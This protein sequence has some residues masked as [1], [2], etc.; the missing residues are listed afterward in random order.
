MMNKL[1]KGV[2][3]AVVALLVVLGCTTSF[4]G[5]VGGPTGPAIGTDEVDLPAEATQSF[6]TAFQ[7]DPVPED[8][9]GPK[10]VVA[11][12]I[13]QDGLTD[14]VSAW[15]QNQP[16]QLHLQR[17]TSAGVISF[18]TVS[19][20]GTTPIAVVAGLEVGQI[21]DDGW[22]DVVVLSKATAFLGLCPTNP[23][24]TISRL[25]GEII[26]LFSP[27][28]AAAV[29]DGDAWTEMMLV[30]PFVA[31]RWIHN[32]YPGIEIVDYNESKTKPEW[33]GFTSLVV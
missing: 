5:T 15:N 30:N 21:N 17:R 11:A 2:G 3:C 16:V 23:P 19:L 33:S 6:F 25:E 1:L 13:D 8:T 12:D 10:F 7:V 28:S 18:R 27:G 20:G 31:D 4:T 22:L 14:L 26:V 29:P 32:Q 24:T 9:A